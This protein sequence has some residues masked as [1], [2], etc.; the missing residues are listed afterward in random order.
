[1][2]YG[3]WV[4]LPGFHAGNLLHT[5][6]PPTPPPPQ[7]LPGNFNRVSAD[8]DDVTVRLL[9][10]LRDESDDVQKERKNPMNWTFEKFFPA[11]LVHIGWKEFQVESCLG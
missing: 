8:G 6:T 4:F 5:H 11:I 3:L 7:L 2:K 9:D 1:M 10:G